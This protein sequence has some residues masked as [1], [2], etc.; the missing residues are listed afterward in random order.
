[1]AG[2]V[3]SLAFEK[4]R[5]SAAIWMMVHSECHIPRSLWQKTY[6]A[7]APNHL[8]PKPDEDETVILRK[9]PRVLDAA[10]VPKQAQVHSSEG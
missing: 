7:L 3:A 1:M 5:Y 2:G 4:T 9:C 8:F 6:G 10:Y